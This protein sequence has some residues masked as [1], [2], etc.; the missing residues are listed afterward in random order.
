[1]RLGYEQLH[2]VEVGKAK[3]IFSESRF[4]FDKSESAGCPYTKKV[5]KPE[6]GL[7]LV[8]EGLG[9]DIGKSFIADNFVSVA[10][11]ELGHELDSMIENNFLHKPDSAQD[12]TARVDALVR[13]RLSEVFAMAMDIVK[14]RAVVDRSVDLNKTGLKTSLIKLVEMPDKTKFMYLAHMGDARVYLSRGGELQQLTTDHCALRSQRDIGVITDDEMR[15]IDQAHDHSRLPREHQSLFHLRHDVLSMTPNNASKI[16]PDVEVYKVKT[17][18]RM[19]IVS[20]NV[21]H[22]LLTRELESILD[23]RHVD[24]EAEEFIEQCA[25][26]ESHNEIGSARGDGGLALAVVISVTDSLGDRKNITSEKVAG[27]KTVDFRETIGGL[28]E[29]VKKI[30]GQIQ[31][32]RKEFERLDESVSKSDR[33]KKQMRLEE[34]FKQ[35]AVA[36]LKVE[37]AKLRA[38]ETQVPPR[39][40]IGEK[41]SVWRDDLDP[42]GFD[43]NVWDVSDYDAIN[44]EYTLSRSNANFKKI[45]RYELERRQNGLILRVGDIVPVRLKNG[46]IAEGFCVIGFES[47]DVI[48]T[49]KNENKTLRARRNALEMKKLVQARMLEQTHRARYAQNL[50][51]DADLHTHKYSDLEEMLSRISE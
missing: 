38:F 37:K 8:A 14:R 31:T 51:K 45:S 44:Y 26:D 47:G 32:A 24:N 16:Q 12:A 15:A 23:A 19:V 13:A 50:V 43:R 18:D 11:S 46:N 28:S 25:R 22:N 5:N 41:T 48:L 30:E 4:D 20:A 35:E 6:H 1:M 42:P 10:I 33:I 36:R 29:D 49:K 39:F 7:F 40:R 27:E 2:S 9:S 34:L 3:G 21:H 17:G